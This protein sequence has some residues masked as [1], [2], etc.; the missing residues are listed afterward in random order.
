MSN[1]L[2]VVTQLPV[3]EENLRQVKSMVEAR[4]SEALS[5]VCTEETLASVKKMRAELR[6]E[7]EQLEGLR[8]QAKKAI[9][10]PY[11][12]FEA[13]YKDCAGDLY[14]WADDTLKDRIGKVEG[15]IKE[16]RSAAVKAYF[17][18]YRLALGLSDA[19]VSFERWGV[20]IRL[21]D[22]LKSLKKSAAEY[23]DSIADDLALIAT[24]EHKDEILVEYKQ[25]LNAS[26]AITTVSARH[27]QMEAERVARE[28]RAE[29][30]AAR[31][32]SEQRVTDVLAASEPVSVAAP[33]VSEVQA[34]AVKTY[35]T[36]FRV[37]GTLE[38]MKALKAF[39][40][41]GGYEYEQL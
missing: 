30:A 10:A 12:N 38:Q 20:K 40:N 26:W 3:I 29:E 2:I 41:D 35:A 25:H 9:M 27:E 23:L 22:S 31:V 28:K 17:D 19:L 21:S 6:K 1:E 37:R 33:E 36:S 15:S 7:F 14:K 8:L 4:V 39:L 11:E 13:V 5:L 16:E 18:E 34:P 24:Q 32:A